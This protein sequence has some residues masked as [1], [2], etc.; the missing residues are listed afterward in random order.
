MD[1]TATAVAQA[2]AD[3]TGL[4]GVDLI[5]YLTGKK[6]GS[7]H[8]VLFWR[9]RTRSNNYGARQG[10]W[11]YVYSTEGSEV[12][13]P[14]QIPARDMLFNLADDIGEQR[15]L[16]A[17]HPEKLAAL[18]N[19]YEAWSA[20]VDADCR[21]LGIEPRTPALPMT[22]AKRPTGPGYIQTGLRE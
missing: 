14:K 2:G 16:A 4:E 11:K 7:P 22:L 15:D 3:P 21:K 6:G 1:I 19:R 18:K 17:A 13:G 5:Q 10:N 9:S 8:E 12:P 20:G